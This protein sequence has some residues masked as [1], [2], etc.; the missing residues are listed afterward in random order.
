MSIALVIENEI[1][2][3]QRIKFVLEL[4][5]NKVITASNSE[6]GFFAFNKNC[7]SIDVILVDIEVLLKSDME[8]LK[9]FKKTIPHIGIIIL[10]KHE[11]L[12]NA[13]LAVKEG[14]SGYL[15][16]PLNAEDLLVAVKSALIKKNL[17]LENAR[18][19]KELFEQREYLNGLHDS[20]VKILLNMLP[21]KL[22]TIPGFNFDVKYKSCDAVGGDMYDVSDIGDYICFYVFDVSSHGILAAVISTIIKSFLKNIEYNYKQGINKR[23][24]P[25]IVLD[26]N[27]QLFFNTAQNV[28]ASLFLGFIDKNLKKLYTVSAGHIT[29]YVVKSDSSLIPWIPRSYTGRV[30]GFRLYLQC[31]PLEPGDKI[32]LF[33]DGVIEASYNNEM[34]GNDNLLKL[35]KD[36]CKDPISSSLERLMESIKYFSKDTFTDDITILGIEIE[37]KSKPYPLSPL[38]YFL[39]GFSYPHLL[40]C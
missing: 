21:D 6:E 28:F 12:Q 33:T 34:F 14:A 24:F 20:A 19:S 38:K 4:G 11:Y 27:L 40:Y 25:E 30:R 37:N 23:R 18:M 32:F 13:I 1:E 17:L 5:G 26:L 36:H 35:L 2:A 29:Q 15:K 22:P 39:L 7:N 31:K 10:T 9:R 8:M 3:L 16:K